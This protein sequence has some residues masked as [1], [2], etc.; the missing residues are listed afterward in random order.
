MKGLPCE[1]FKDNM[2]DCTNNGSSSKATRALL[3]GEGVDGWMNTSECS[4][5]PIYKIVRRN[6]CNKEYLHVEP[7]EQ[8]K[9]AGWMAG[10]NFLYTCDSRFPN[11]YPLSIHDRQETWE[12]YEHLSI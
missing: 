12:Q 3:I 10:G 4:D 7:I 6:I 11:S 2:G 5:M 8:P 9:G 1:I